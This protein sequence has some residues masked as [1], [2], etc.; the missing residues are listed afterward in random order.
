MQR[1]L[2]EDRNSLAKELAFIGQLGS[3][4]DSGALDE[5]QRA[6]RECQEWWPGFTLQDS[7]AIYDAIRARLAV[8][9]DY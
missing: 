8:V 7:V 3:V 6:V 4:G 9:W 2:P 5:Y 1:Q